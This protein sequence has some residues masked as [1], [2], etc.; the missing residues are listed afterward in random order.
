MPDT[1]RTVIYETLLLFIMLHF[2]ILPILLSLVTS[3][4]VAVKVYHGKYGSAGAVAAISCLI[5]LVMFD[6]HRF[7]LAALCL[8]AGIEGCVLGIYF[9]R[10]RSPGN[11]LVAA[12]CFFLICCTFGSVIHD[13]V[14]RDSLGEYYSRSVVPWVRVFLSDLGETGDASERPGMVHKVVVPAEYIHFMHRVRYLIEYGYPAIIIITAITMG[15][16][17]FFQS[18]RLLVKTGFMQDQAIPFDRW[19][20]PDT[21]SIAFVIAAFAACSRLFW[22]DAEFLPQMG[23]NLLLPVFWIYFFQGLSISVFFATAWGL[24]KP[25]RIIFYFLFAIRPHFQL[26]LSGI[27]IADT[28]ADFRRF[29]R[30]KHPEADP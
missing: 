23:F 8:V 3:V 24:P 10:S 14:R 2:L 28:W 19:R 22:R 30:P 16:V 15:F 18:R 17:S 20:L 9:R 29:L 12:V 6:E 13:Q 7:I 11:I 25:I 27:G 4:S 1:H 21:L 5:M 26:I